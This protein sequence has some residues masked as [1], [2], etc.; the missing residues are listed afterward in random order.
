MTN[1]EMRS[2]TRSDYAVRRLKRGEVGLT[3]AWAAAEGGSLGRHDD[4]CFYETEPDGRI[5]VHMLF[6]IVMGTKKP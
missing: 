3:R 4:A 1:L 2:D 6:G 5:L